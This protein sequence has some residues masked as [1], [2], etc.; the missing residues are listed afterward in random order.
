M[1]HYK[2]ILNS[3][4]SISDISKD[5]NLNINDIIIL[6]SANSYSKKNNNLPFSKKQLYNHINKDLHLSGFSEY[7][8]YNNRINKLVRNHYFNPLNSHK[9]QFEPVKYLV[10]RRLTRLLQ[11]ITQVYNNNQIFF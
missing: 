4:K 10:T 8:L 6:L 5:L 1:A 3:Y 2:H 11:K 9:R 7:T